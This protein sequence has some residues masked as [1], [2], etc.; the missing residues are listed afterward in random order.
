[1]TTPGPFFA[2]RPIVKTDQGLGN[3][4]RRVRQ[5]LALWIAAAMLSI[6]ALVVY[7]SPSSST[8]APTGQITVDGVVTLNSTPARSGQTIFSGSTISTD[9]DSQSL[10][11]LGN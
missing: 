7:G 9:Q 4:R 8:K 2:S 10:L 5:P 11:D 1:M 6:P 3:L